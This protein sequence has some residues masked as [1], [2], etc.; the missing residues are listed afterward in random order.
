MNIIRIV[1]ENALNIP[2]GTQLHYTSFFDKTKVSDSFSTGLLWD[3]VKIYNWQD[4]LGNIH[5]I[6]ESDLYPAH[7]DI[8][9]NVIVLSNCK[10]GIEG[11]KYY[12]VFINEKECQY[13]KLEKLASGKYGPAIPFKAYEDI[14]Y[15]N[16]NSGFPLGQS[17]FK[18]R[19]EAEEYI[20]IAKRAIFRKVC[21]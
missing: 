12:K 7:K 9:V 11:E 4:A 10:F 2:I 18:T 16:T 17:R 3:S 13:H 6:K 1:K 15:D 14:V 20:Q 21:N 8:Y 5:S 19:E